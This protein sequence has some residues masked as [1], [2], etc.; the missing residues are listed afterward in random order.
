M[1]KR[2][3]I[4]LFIANAI[5]GMAQGMSMIAIPW[6][7][8]QKDALPFFGLIYILTNIC[9]L[10]WV[11]FSGTIVD[12]YDRK[13][14]FLAITA[15]VGI[16]ILSFSI[17]GFKTGGLSMTMVG[18]VFLITFLNYN[19]HYPTLY[20]FVQEITTQDKYSKMT[21][22]LEVIGQLTTISAGAGATLLLEGTTN[23]Q[24]EIFGFNL[25][26]GFDI[27]PW[28]I[29]EILMI[30]GVTY[31]IAFILI[32]LISYKPLKERVFEEGSVWTRIKTGI[33]YL[34]SN[35]P[36]FWFGILSFM[37]FTVV[38]LEA[39]FL[40]VTY[41]KNHLVESGDVYAN[42]KMAYSTGAIAI[43]VMIG[44]LFKRVNLVL[45]TIIMTILMAVNLLQLSFT[46]SIFIFFCSMFMIGI[47]NAGVR[48]TRMT[49]LFKNVP[50]QYFGRAGSVFFI[51]HTILRIVLLLLFKEAFFHESNN[52][53]Y[54]YLI[55]AI[56]LLVTA[57]IFIS[58]YRS[59]DLSL[60]KSN[61]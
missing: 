49:Y 25:N 56:I 12:R 9:S 20:A 5:S 8:A 10:F 7:F 42:S 36:I 28:A 39:F 48:I 24:M 19:I 34:K 17:Y 29:H 52:I 59:F 26:L 58:K 27:S 40:G 11:P 31:F 47:L 13:K 46:N 57:I 22:V 51:F 4:L 61:L 3:I 37:V 60:A 54:A 21:S 43:G 41:V 35:K 14:I 53:V 18:L 38:L 23:G 50:N 30:D 6:F 1:N 2:A 33:G 55:L 16:I 32:S 44:F 45:L 15:F